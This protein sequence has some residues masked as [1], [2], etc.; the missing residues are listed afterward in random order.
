M[1]LSVQSFEAALT[2]LV[3]HVFREILGETFG[4]L[5]HFIGIRIEGFRKLVDRNGSASIPRRGPDLSGVDIRPLVDASLHLGAC[6]S[7]GFPAVTPDT[8]SFITS[9]RSRRDEH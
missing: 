7:S 6:F 3:S 4:D 5:S 2:Y 8:R 1:K 9:E